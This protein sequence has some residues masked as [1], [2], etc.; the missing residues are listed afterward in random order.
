MPKEQESK[1]WFGIPPKRCEFC[2]RGIGKYFVDGKTKKGYW[3]IMCPPC[4]IQFGCGVGVGLGQRYHEE[5]GKWIKVETTP[6]D[7]LS[8]LIDFLTDMRNGF[9]MDLNK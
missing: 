1:Q 2:N 6:Y 8:K 7:Q 3:G 9:L 5:G 4:H